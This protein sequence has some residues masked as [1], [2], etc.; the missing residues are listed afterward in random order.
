MMQF[1][2][3]LGLHIQD[4]EVSY[5]KM[6]FSAMLPAFFYSVEYFHPNGFIAH[7]ALV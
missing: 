1:G 2:K 5:N 6:T 4:L 7:G 3:D